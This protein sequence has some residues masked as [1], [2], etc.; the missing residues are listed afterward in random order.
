[1]NMCS[2][3]VSLEASVNSRFFSFLCRSHVPLSAAYLDRLT[4]T[5]LPGALTWSTITGEHACLWP[6]WFTHFCSSQARQR[7]AFRD[8]EEEARITRR[9]GMLSRFDCSLGKQWLRESRDRPS[10]HVKTWGYRVH[11]DQNSASISTVTWG[12]GRTLLNNHP[13]PTPGRNRKTANLI[14]NTVTKTTQCKKSED[15]ISVSTIHKLSSLI[16]QKKNFHS[17]IFLPPW[18]SACQAVDRTILRSVV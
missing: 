14:T 17:F 10:F 7:L 6:F 2:Q 15:D 8:N 13:T 3:N 18:P 16:R 5:V 12:R 9:Q 4:A 1:M 11:E